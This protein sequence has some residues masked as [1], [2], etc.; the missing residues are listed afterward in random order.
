[1]H[2]FSEHLLENP[3]RYTIYIYCRL[4]LLDRPA[5]DFNFDWVLDAKP[6]AKPTTSVITTQVPGASL[7]SPTRTTS[8]PGVTTA[9]TGGPTSTPGVTTATTTGS[10]APPT[11][12]DGFREEA[13]DVSNTKRSIHNASP[14]QL[15]SS[16]NQQAQSYAEKLAAAKTPSTHSNVKGQGENLANKCST[17]GNCIFC[18]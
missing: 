14:F 4:L 1:M 12:L 8:A 18:R 6:P 17:N 15:D 2:N 7:T 3:A 5:G 13:L 11:A 9:T 10:P 16:L